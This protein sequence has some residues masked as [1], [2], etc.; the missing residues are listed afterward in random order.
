L[1]VNHFLQVIAKLVE[2]ANAVEGQV[3]RRS[4]QAIRPVLTKLG[5]HPSAVSVIDHPLSD[6]F[7]RDALG[8]VARFIYIAA[9]MHGEVVSKELQW[10][11]G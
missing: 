3:I 2:G 11:G 9:E 5:H 1:S 6:L 4:R 8:E 10:D 7:Y